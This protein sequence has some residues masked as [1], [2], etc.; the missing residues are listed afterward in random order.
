LNIV[1]HG[2]AAGA[3]AGFFTG[4]AGGCAGAAGTAVTL[5]DPEEKPKSAS[6]I[7]SR[8]TTT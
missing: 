7:N 1:T 2:F 5:L 3:S 4:A 6:S 8:T